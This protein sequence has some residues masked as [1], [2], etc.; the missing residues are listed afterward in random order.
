MYDFVDRHPNALAN[1]GRFMLWAMRGWAQS[2]AKRSCP[3]VLLH[4]GFA[5]LGASQALTDFHITMVLLYR[6]AL[7]APKLGNMSCCRIHEDEAVLLSL[8]QAVARDDSA[9]VAGTLQHLVKQEAVQPVAR[10]MAACSVQ[11]VLAGLDLN[12]TAAKIEE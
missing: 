7:D 11:L 9:M 5:G 1:P 10:A 8:W 3:P 4:R 6:N 12:D 2:M